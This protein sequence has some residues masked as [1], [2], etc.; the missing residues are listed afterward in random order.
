LAYF[1]LPPSEEVQMLLRSLRG[2][3]HFQW[4][5][6]VRKVW[7]YVG[8]EARAR[9]LVRSLGV[10]VDVFDEESVKSKTLYNHK[11]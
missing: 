4:E 2:L 10:E 7:D 5:R 6:N 1:A 11:Y 9:E 3:E 8:G